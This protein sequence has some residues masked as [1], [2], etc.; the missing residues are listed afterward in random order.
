MTLLVVLVWSILCSPVLTLFTNESLKGELDPSYRRL[1]TCRPGTIV[2][3]SIFHLIS[4]DSGH[5]PFNLR[6]S[7]V[8]VGFEECQYLE[9]HCKF[10]IITFKVRE[11]CP[12]EEM[13]SIDVE[14]NE[15]GVRKTTWGIDNFWYRQKNQ[16]TLIQGVVDRGNGWRNVGKVIVYDH[17]KGRYEKMENCTVYNRFVVARFV[18][19]MT[20]TIVMILL[21]GFMTLV[22]AGIIFGNFFML[23]SNEI[24]EM[25]NYVRVTNTVKESSCSPKQKL[26]TDVKQ[27][28][29]TTNIE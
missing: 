17:M 7:K 3:G 27:N 15:T 23:G 13:E 24:T 22:I 11:C 6:N 8:Q 25:T 4:D 29:S 10:E 19:P 18:I 12:E 28:N 2:R 1:S 26:D 9:M 5:N 14:Y 16:Y 21:G 20:F